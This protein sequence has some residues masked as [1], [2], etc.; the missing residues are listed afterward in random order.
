MTTVQ[1][2]SILL[3]LR[4]RFANALL[5]GSKSIELRRRAPAARAGIVVLL[6]SSSP[7]RAVVGAVQLTATYAGLPSDIWTKFGH[8][9]GISKG[10]FDDY[11]AGSSSAYALSISRPTP[12]ERPVPLRELRA[13]LGV[14]PPQSYRYLSGRQ[15]A[16][17]GL[18]ECD[19]MAVMRLSEGAATELQLPLG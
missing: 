5:D 8:Q 14:L 2:R 19:C 12:F 18:R 10:E 17:L 11:F 13:N 1:D 16:R 6:Y 7:A 4:P 9:T 15:I 3:S